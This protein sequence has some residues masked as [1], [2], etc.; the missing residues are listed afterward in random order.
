LGDPLIRTPLDLLKNRPKRNAF[1]AVRAK[2]LYEDV[3]GQ[4]LELIS[5]GELQPGSR[6][7]TERDLAEQVGV[8]RNVLREAFRV[9]EERGI[10]L[11]RAGDGRYV[12]TLD[13]SRPDPTGDAIGQIE[14]A[15]IL[16]IL[17]S[18]EILE[19]S[20]AML[21]CARITPQEVAPLR[22]AASRNSSWDDNL[23]FH[24]TLASVTHNFILERLVRQQIELLRDVH[25]REH[26]I[27]GRRSHDLLEEHREIA[28]AVIA[29]DAARAQSLMRSHLRHTRESVSRLHR[30]DRQPA[31]GG[32]PA[33]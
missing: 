33:A 18:R 30:T 3:V 5:A 2:R 8:S 31:D 17:E 14:V 19:T 16:D 24:T 29:R 22:A 9:L 26:Y 15:T 10:I 4:V 11:S 20:V 27:R 6:L 32:P 1:R 7:P 12:R 25:Q 28:E 23:A 13:P 21:G